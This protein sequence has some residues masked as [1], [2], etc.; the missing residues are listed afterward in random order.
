MQKNTAKGGVRMILTNEADI[1][2]GKSIVSVQCD[3]CGKIKNSIYR[4]VIKGRKYI[5]KDACTHCVGHKCAEITLKKRQENIYSKVIEMCKSKGYGLNTTK[6]EMLNNTTYIEY[7]CPKHGK[8]TMRI[9]NF[10]I[11]KGCPDCQ[12]EEASERFRADKEHVIASVAACGGELM[13][14]D[15]YVNNTTKNLKIR[16]PGCGTIFV[17]SLR[18][19]VQHGGQLCSNCRKS[20]SLGEA[21]IR[22]YLEEH[23]IDFLQQHWFAD[24]RDVNPLP[25]DFYISDINTIIEFDGRQHFSETNYF[26]YGLEKTMYHDSIKNKYCED[27]GIHL[28]RIPYTKIN[29]IEQ[30]LDKEFT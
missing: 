19:F 30:I 12:H 16:C 17:T 2:N 10:I 18:N 4:N 22:V 3:Y 25:F 21:K 20:E 24:C 1:K 7:I 11:G 5:D 9:S 26:S 28:I 27:K 13:N 15:D 29:N 23:N 14:P 8:H 6:E